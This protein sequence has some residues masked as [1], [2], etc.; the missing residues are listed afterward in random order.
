VCRN[1]ILSFLVAVSVILISADL[2]KEHPDGS[3]QLR[4]AYVIPAKG[5]VHEAAEY[6]AKVLRERS[7]GRMDLKLYP[8]AQLG[9]G[10]ELME[11]LMIGSV[12]MTVTGGAPIGWYFPEYGAVEAPFVFRDYEHM[13]RVLNGEAGEEVKG[14]FLHRRGIRILGWW[15]RGPRYLTTSDRRVTSPEDLRGLK[16]RVPELPAYIEAWRLLGTNPTPITLSEAFMA[17]KLGVVEGQEN[18]LETIH[19]NSFHEVQK[20][21]MRTQHLLGFYMVSI[22]EA[23]Y[24]GLSQQDRDTIAETVEQAGHLE[25][26]LMTKYEQEY[27]QH[28]KKAGLEFVDVNREAFRRQV[29]EQLPRRFEDEWAPGF[30]ERIVNTP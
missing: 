26:E 15:H 1:I 22:S 12:D 3:S 29:V 6:L 10:R 9:K 11:G 8:S 13:D 5:P 16:L 27:E 18:P 19:T 20:Y 7:G 25:H 24:Q 17:L 21:V 30:Y 2:L 14:A 4:L 28:M 23:T